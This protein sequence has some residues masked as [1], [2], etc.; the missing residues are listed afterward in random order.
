MMF[1]LMELH[2]IGSMTTLD[3]TKGGTDG[4]CRDSTNGDL[5]IKRSG[6]WQ[7]A[8][9]MQGGPAASQAN[10]P[11]TVKNS[12]NTVTRALNE[13]NGIVNLPATDA[14]VSNGATVTLKKSDGTTTSVGNAGLNS[15]A[16]AV[17]AAGAI[18]QV[19]AAA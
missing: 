2:P 5:Y 15:P 4:I 11:I 1:M 3:N 9:S 7:K 14:I 10:L 16:T 13:V 19:N 6:T 17:V 8:I 18:S 12:A